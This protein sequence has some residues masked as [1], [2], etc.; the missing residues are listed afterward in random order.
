MAFEKLAMNDDPAVQYLLD[1]F[2]IQDTL[3]R[4]ASG[5]DDH[6]NGM[7]GTLTI[8]S[9]VFTEDAVLDYSAAGFPFGKCSYTELASLMRG[10]GKTMG[11]MNS[12]FASWQHMLGLPQVDI[13][14]DTAQARTDLLATHHGLSHAGRNW[15]LF[16]ACVFQDKLIRA[17]NG[18]R[19]CARLLKV[20]YVETIETLDGISALPELIGSEV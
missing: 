20:H 1:R 13:Q 3:A 18:W 14:G 8:W 19:I 7:R 6:Q 15:H 17:V 12:S 10:D 5:Q 16:N 4:Y 9:S 11:V 2:A